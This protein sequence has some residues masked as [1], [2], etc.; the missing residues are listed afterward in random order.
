[1]S[2]KGDN[3]CRALRSLSGMWRCLICGSVITSNQL[4]EVILC[5][6]RAI[7]LALTPSD[8]MKEE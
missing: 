2:S 1:M 7:E 4:M 5:V 8:P 6:L 3:A